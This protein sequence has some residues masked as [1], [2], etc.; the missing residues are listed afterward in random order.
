[1]AAHVA[2]ENVV[3]E[4]SATTGGCVETAQ[5]ATTGHV[6]EQVAALLAAPE[7]LAAHYVMEIVCVG[8]EFALRNSFTQQQNVDTASSVEGAKRGKT[9]LLVFSGIR[10]AV[11]VQRGLESKREALVQRQRKNVAVRGRC[12]NGTRAGWQRDR[13]KVVCTCLYRV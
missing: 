13:N 1:M 6:D 11:L 4:R 7:Y 10:A 8:V 2:P 9:D 12:V 3:V 5:Q